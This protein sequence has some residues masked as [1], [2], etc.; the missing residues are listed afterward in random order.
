M[1]AILLFVKRMKNNEIY[2]RKGNKLGTVAD[3]MLDEHM[4]RARYV[5]L[6]FGGVLG[7]AKKLFAVAPEALELDTENEC[8]V[9]DAEKSQLA[10]A[11]GFD[12]NDPPLEPDPRFMPPPRTVKASDRSAG[13]ATPI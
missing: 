10:E 12:P 1:P 7:A 9:M 8:F 11:E 13:R 3:V 4:T 2:D 5:V 6:A